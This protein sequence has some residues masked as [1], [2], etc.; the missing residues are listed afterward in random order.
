MQSD[1]SSDVTRVDL[2]LRKREFVETLEY[3]PPAKIVKDVGRAAA[4]TDT[5]HESSDVGPDKA[6]TYSP[7]SPDEP[8]RRETPNDRTAGEGNANP[9]QIHGAGSLVACE[10]KPDWKSRNCGMYWCRACKYEYRHGIQP[11]D[12]EKSNP[13]RNCLFGSDEGDFRH[14]HSLWSRKRYGGDKELRI[15]GKTFVLAELAQVLAGAKS[16][17]MAYLEYTKRTSVVFT[18]ELNMEIVRSAGG[19]TFV[20]KFTGEFSVR[21]PKRVWSEQLDELL[22]PSEELMAEFNS[23]FQPADVL[24]LSKLSFVQSGTAWMENKKYKDET[25]DDWLTR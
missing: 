7:E 3:A 6:I 21:E 12:F 10:R 16:E 22:T 25:D 13:C 2:P 9:H 14:L 8:Q 15:Q 4:E 1:T 19:Q 17:L 23:I 5:G 24:L 11:N 18:I 20:K